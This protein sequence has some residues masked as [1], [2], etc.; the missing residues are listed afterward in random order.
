MS[1]T[2]T[3]RSGNGSPTEE[4]GATQDASR[5]AAIVTPRQHASQQVAQTQ[6][7][8]CSAT[9]IDDHSCVTYVEVRN[10]ETTEAAT[11]VFSNAVAWFADRGVTNRGTCGSGES[12]C[13]EFCPTTAAATDHACGA[14]PAKACASRRTR[15][16]PTGPDQRRV[17]RFQRTLA[18]GWVFKKCSNAGS[19]SIAA[20][21]VWI[22]DY[23]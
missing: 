18:E 14:A 7:G 20:L 19:P 5:A 23:E 12:P 22:H 1:S 21:P 17:E 4:D 13:S 6:A 8:D 10:D 3:S 9:V 2:S 11:E 15:P 16:G